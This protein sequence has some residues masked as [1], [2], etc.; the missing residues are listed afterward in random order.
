MIGLGVLQFICNNVEG[1][2][3]GQNA[4]YE[5]LPIDP[6]TGAMERYGVYITTE[7]AQVSQGSDQHQFINIMV[8]IGEGA[9]DINGTLVP[10]KYETE[11]ILNAIQALI[12]DALTP[13]YREELCYLQINGTGIIHRDVRILPSTSK[14]RGGTLTN[15]AIVKSLTAEVYYK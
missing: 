9:K 1:L 5:D 13:Q 2:K 7:A 4:F 3:I 10:E 14:V 11:R 12:N 6:M 15:G 8:A